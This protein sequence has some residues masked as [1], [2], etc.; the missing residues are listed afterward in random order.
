MDASYYLDHR[1]GPVAFSLHPFIHRPSLHPFIHRVRLLSQ[2][3]ATKELSPYS[4]PF[5]R[6]EFRDYHPGIPMSVQS[7]TLRPVAEVPTAVQGVGTSDA[8]D[9]SDEHQ[10]VDPDLEFGLRP[11]LPDDNIL[12]RAEGLTFSWGAEEGETL[13]IQVLKAPDATNFAGVSMLHKLHPL[14]EHHHEHRVPGWRLRLGQFLESTTVHYLVVFLLVVD[15][16]L[17]GVC[18]ATANDS[19]NCA[20]RIVPPPF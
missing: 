15:V 13:H 3:A 20:M 1:A 7:D 14:I 2:L 6:T 16:L 12:E 17:V 4:S 18:C 9:G 5:R 8:N 10:L 19:M 11:G